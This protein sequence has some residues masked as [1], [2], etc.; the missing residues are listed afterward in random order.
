VPSST[1]HTLVVS[2][3]LN[4]LD[5]GN[6]LLVDLPDYSIRRLQAVQNVSAR[7]IYQLRHSDHIS[8]SGFIALA[9]CPGTN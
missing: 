7:L 4:K 5:F 3:M 6:A 2:L 1:L 8:D 9:L